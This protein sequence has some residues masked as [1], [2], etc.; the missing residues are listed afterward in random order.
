MSFISF[1]SSD[2]ICLISSGD[3][4]VISSSSSIR[5]RNAS[6]SSSSDNYT[7]EQLK[8]FLLKKN[9]KYRLVSNDSTKSLAAWWR[10]FGLINVQNENNKF[11]QI[12]GYSIIVT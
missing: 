11:E 8:Q 3:L 9:Q 1:D 6:N 12:A 5:V 10:A 7:P 4:D 2:D